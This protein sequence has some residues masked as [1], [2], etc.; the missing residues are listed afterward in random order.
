M[1]EL[2]GLLKSMGMQEYESKAYAYLLENGVSTA[3]QISKFGEIPLPR[4]Y[5][6]LDGL[7]KRG[8]VK[9]MTSR[10]KKYH[11]VSAESLKSL[12]EEKKEKMKNEVERSETLYKKIMLLAPRQKVKMTEPE[13]QDFWIVTG[14]KNIIKSA[15]EQEKKAS[16]EILIFGED[17]SWFNEFQTHIR[18]KIKDGTKIKILCNINP[19]TKKTVEKVIA[20]GIEARE[21]DIDGLMGHIID[22]NTVLICTKVPRPGVKAEQYYAIPGNDKLFSYEAIT[23]ENPIML[24]TFTTYF[25]LAWMKGRTSKDVLRK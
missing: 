13:K 3:E 8:I 16:K 5:E 15:I 23:T 1:E 9:V 24:K 6:T 10:P 18:K 20:A 22:N 4:V 7:H 11:V 14:R 12:I 25:N 17:L 19:K 21:L 2:V